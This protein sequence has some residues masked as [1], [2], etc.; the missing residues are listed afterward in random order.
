M[1]IKP[2]PK[3]LI[4]R[5]KKVSHRLNIG[6]MKNID[7]RTEKNPL[8]IDNTEFFGY[9]VRE[10]NV[11]RNFPE[12]KVVL[13]KIHSNLSAKE[14]IKKI[15]EMVREHNKKFKSEKYELREPFAYAINDKTIAMAKADFP[16]ASE[17]LGFL[18]EMT[19][20]PTERGKKFF[21]KLKK[22]YN[23]NE[24]QLKEAVYEITKNSA[25]REDHLLLVGCKK[26]KNKIKFIFV[27]LIDLN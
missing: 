5:L 27:P 12:E 10:M 8:Q 16:S 13:K 7:Y 2:L 26:E 19:L 22:E 24:E 15:K 6:K 23:V 9:R 18:R 1:V 21:E 17:I 11:K 3:E 25:F 4:K 20:K 14:K